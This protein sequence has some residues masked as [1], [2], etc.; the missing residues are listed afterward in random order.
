MDRATAEEFRVPWV[1]VRS[2]AGPRDDSGRAWKAAGG[3]LRR[4]FGHITSDRGTV[5][6]AL[7]QHVRDVRGA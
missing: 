5:M 3:G 7:A 2:R 1:S 6:A 4:V